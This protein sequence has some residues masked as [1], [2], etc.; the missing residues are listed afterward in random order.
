MKKY[1]T[2]FSLSVAIFSA[3]PVAI[4]QDHLTKQMLA[5]RA[6]HYK[7]THFDSSAHAIEAMDKD[8]EEC[9]KIL[10]KDSLEFLDLENLHKL[11]YT[12]ESG[13]DRLREDGFAPAGKIDAMDE[14][15]QAF[16]ASSENQLEADT[17]AWFKKLGTAYDDLKSTKTVEAP[18]KEFYELVIK[19][20]KFS[21]SELIVPAGKKVKLVIDNQDATPEEFESEELKREKVIA[22]NSKGTVF[23]GPLD[24]G[25]YH[26]TGEFNESTAK[27]VV[28]AK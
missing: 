24:A 1:F 27:G 11:S 3:P 28:I 2:L 19:D 20:H 7:H 23:I 12:L 4:A 15:V 6:D 8:I 5:P 14:A 18:K 13:V 16:H 25:T 21:P 22:G 17:R 9:K 10:A 26:F